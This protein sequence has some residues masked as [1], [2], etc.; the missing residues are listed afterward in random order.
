MK[1]G[2]FDCAS[3]VVNILYR[4]GDLLVRNSSILDWKFVDKLQRENSFAVGFIQDTIWEKYVW[5][6]QRNFVVL[7]CEMN[8]DPVGYVLLTPGKRFGGYG[9]VQQI[10]VRNDARRL[11]YG[12]ALIEVVRRFCEQVSL[13]GVTLRCRVDLESNH[14]WRALGFT[15]YGTWEK[16]KVNHV[17][18]K[19]SD[20]INLWR[21]ELNE[22]IPLLFS[23]EV[24]ANMLA[25]ERAA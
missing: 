18:F 7:I 5:G 24:E 9:K 4:R 14:F 17:G 15:R 20:D 3:G 25:A 6:G 1:L 22:R 21:I 12:T 11:E 23:A 19:A 10:V 13:K 16:G 2:S 8:L